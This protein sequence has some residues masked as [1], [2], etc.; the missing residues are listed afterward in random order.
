LDFRPPPADAYEEETPVAEEFR[1]LAF[2]GVADELENP[3]EEK[4]AE[5]VWPEAVDEDAGEK[6]CHR[7]HDG[8]DAQG[9]AEAV[10]AVLVA[11]GVLRDPLLVGAV[12]QHAEDDT[13]AAGALHKLAG[14]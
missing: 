11:G 14:G 8:W 7:E 6:N 10:Y 2:E 12:T 1:G 9:V 13:T 5:S 3:S 4:E